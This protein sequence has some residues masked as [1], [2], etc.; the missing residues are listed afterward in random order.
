MG[1]LFKRG[2]L[3]IWIACFA[4]LLNAL[5]PS[6]SH[7]ISAFNG[8][9]AQPPLWMEVCTVDGA[10]FVAPVSDKVPDTAPSNN[11]IA[12]Q[13]E[14]CP[15]CLSHAGTFA[16]PPPSLTP[17]AVSGQHD[18]LPSLFYRSPQPLFSWAAAHPRAPPV[19][20]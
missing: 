16:L 2:Q 4:I 7:A 1:T 14:H 15:F 19:A 10:K 5:A 18:L 9:S 11:S 17:F 6:I 12:H 3:R 20:S 13:S 8:H